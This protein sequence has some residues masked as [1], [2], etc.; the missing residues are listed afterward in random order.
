M[1]ETAHDEIVG[2]GQ[3]FLLVVF[4]GGEPASDAAQRQEVV[5]IQIRHA[6]T[7]IIT[8]ARR[9]SKLV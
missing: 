2:N 9:P 8:T 3:E 6:P 4:G 5:H 7:E 1:F